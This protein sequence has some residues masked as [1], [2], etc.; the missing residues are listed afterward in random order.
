MASA[1]KLV[2]SERVRTILS[3][4][5]ERSVRVFL[6]EALCAI[7]CTTYTQLVPVLLGKGWTL[8]EISSAATRTSANI[9][10]VYAGPKIDPRGILGV[11]QALNI[12]PLLSYDAENDGLR[13]MERPDRILRGSAWLRKIYRD[14]MLAERD[15]E[16]ALAANVPIVED[17]EA[18]KMAVVYAIAKDGRK[19]DKVMLA[20]QVTKS[21]FRTVNLM[22]YKAATLS[23]YLEPEFARRRQN[24]QRETQTVLDAAKA[25]KKA[26]ERE[27]EQ[28]AQARSAAAVALRLAEEARIAEARRAEEARL[29][30]EARVAEA[31]RKAAEARVAEERRL[32]EAARKAEEES[33][34]E[35]EE[36]AWRADAAA[37]EAAAARVAVETV[38]EPET[39]PPPAAEVQSER[40]STE[41]EWQ[42]EGKRLQR[43]AEV[44]AAKAAIV[45]QVFADWQAEEIQRRKQQ[46]VALEVRLEELRA[47]CAAEA[48]RLA[49]LQASSPVEAANDAVVV[50]ETDTM[51]T[52]NGAAQPVDNQPE[53]IDTTN[54]SGTDEAVLLTPANYV[55]YRSLRNL[56]E[57][58][59][60][61]FQMQSRDRVTNVFVDCFA[62]R[63]WNG[64]TKSSVRLS[65]MRQHTGLTAPL[66]SGVWQVRSVPVTLSAPGG[67]SLVGLVTLK[68]LDKDFIRQHIRDNVDS[69]FLEEAKRQIADSL[70]ADVA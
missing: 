20:M 47:Q 35:A 68:I 67:S 12:V 14:G 19:L 48:A 25:V 15:L 38:A 60:D 17:R 9:A 18:L 58:L 13:E 21:S 45:Q 6:S 64:S 34:R 3:D 43:D 37:K 61:D 4:A 42:A 33:R 30:E 50:H 10:M 32:A 49:G 27:D 54:G 53:S 66:G 29:A 52:V 59:A 40:T 41:D 51:V 28:A 5:G 22:A 62:K 8:E 69:W 55:A 23:S 11:F 31:S 16:H 36:A 1:Y 70:E 39:E 57:V 7:E 44:A 26:K 56:V 2:V 24:A 65:L 46:V 63:I